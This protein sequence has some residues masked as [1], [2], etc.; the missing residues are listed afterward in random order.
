MLVVD[1]RTIQ[2]RALIHALH[3]LLS[4]DL[5]NLKLNLEIFIHH[6]KYRTKQDSGK[7]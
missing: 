2:Y 4:L 1:R 6:Q 3:T 7:T 5:Q